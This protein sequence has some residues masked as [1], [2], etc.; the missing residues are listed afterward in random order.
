M[1]AVTAD[2]MREIEQRSV[3][4]GVPLD[5]LME[6]AGLA[7]ADAVASRLERVY[8]AV[9][10]VLVGPGNNG[11]DGLV[12]A[13]HLASRGAKV[14]AFGLTAR[15]DPDEKRALAEAAGVEFV[16]AAETDGDAGRLHAASA[17]SDVVIDAVLG[18]GRARPV[19]EPL[20][21]WLSE[22]REAASPVVA[23][24]LPTGLDADS[25][26]F[27][28]NGLRSDL[29]LML[30]FPKFGP[31][32]TA[33]DG[34]CGEIQVL[35]IGIPDGLADKVSAEW[36][37]AELA[38]TLLPTRPS[39]ANKGTFGRTL[40]AGGS[41]NYLGAP[42]LAARTAVRSGA[43]LVYLA[44]AEPVHN[45][46][47]GQVQ[48]AIYQ[49]LPASGNA[50]FDLPSAGNELIAAADTM[51]SLLI[52]PG[53]GQ[54]PSSVGF[55]E[56]LVRGLPEEPPVVLD[57]DALNIVARM[58]AWSETLKSPTVLTP[59]PGEMARLL[60]T[61]V[62]EV[63]EDRAA[64]ATE[65]ASRFDATVVLKG[66][67]TLIATPDGQMRISPWVNSGLAKAGTG[68]VLAGLLAGLL[69]QTPGS[70]FDAASLAV[71]LHG[72]A[73]EIARDSIGERG[74]TAG[75][76]ADAV[77]AAFRQLEP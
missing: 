54:S 57:A 26:R 18:T 21:G 31:L 6:N 50:D 55:V 10:V 9:A 28:D 24:D 14:T 2:Q 70:P 61:S 72:L 5:T 53:L 56:Q 65:A 68:D 77:P 47:A 41:R 58:P 75:D 3:D 49:P 4:A 45:L 69:A 46:I 38:K 32:V 42:L 37:T 59:H 12:A 22:V 17:Q 1:K 60:G 7:V 13:R 11:S 16:A 43:G 15:P 27:D 52:G 64:A 73:G 35:D 19:E 40:I 20:A 44:T 74:M 51:D 33:G 48:E 76:V 39:D 71:Y 8:G 36:I 62:A 29:T 30:G 67:A 25:G 66:A 23:I 63:Q 34:L